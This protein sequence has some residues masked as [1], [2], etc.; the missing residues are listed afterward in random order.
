MLFHILPS[1]SWWYS[2]LP[3]PWNCIVF[4]M[5]Y[6]HSCFCNCQ[7]PRCL[8]TQKRHLRI[9]Y[10]CAQNVIFYRS[11]NVYASFFLSEGWTDNCHHEYQQKTSSHSHKFRFLTVY[12]IITLFFLYQEMSL[13][14]HQQLFITSHILIISDTPC[15]FHINT[16]Q[17]RNAEKWNCEY[18]HN[19]QCLYLSVHRSRFSAV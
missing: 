9:L 13:T 7:A 18:P 15:V 6:I 12:I 5:Y 2:F 8:E 16:D 1:R 17:L 11:I 4:S 14:A 3:W 19:A 10:C